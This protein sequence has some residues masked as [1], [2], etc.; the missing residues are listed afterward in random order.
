MSTY[1]FLKKIVLLSTV[2]F[3][4]P[5][6]AQYCYNFNFHNK[7]K[8]IKNIYSSADSTR[9]KKK[10]NNGFYF[11]ANLGFYSA[12]RY[13]AQYYNGSEE[14][15]SGV[16]KVDSVFQYQNNYQDI[17]N[18]LNYDFYLP[19]G[20]LPI[21]MKYSP[22]FLIGFYAK[23]SFKNS[24]IF[25]QFN[26][27]KLSTKD[28]FTLIIEDP[29]NSSSDPV[30]KQE[31]ISG[32]EHRTNIDI[33]YSYTFNPKKK[34]KP[35]IEFGYNLNNTKFIDNKIKIENLE[36]SI[37]NN[38]YSYYNIK[39]SGI[40]MGAFLGGGVELNFSESVSVNPGFNLYWIKINLGKY[41][42]KFKPN[43]SLFV[44]IILNGLL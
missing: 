44:R 1:S 42:D 39:Q 13:T 27:S 20:G 10:N 36:Y 35:Y 28:V 5:A 7:E 31:E 8:S 24:G 34:N 16:N 41:N 3:P 23:Y 2:L 38:Y 15:K 25:M 43:Y 19:E 21:K 14:N 29:N 6:N 40:G 33:G 37:A 22:A 9:H 12:N 11:G 32:S 17:R 18:V 26:F 30:Y 4:L